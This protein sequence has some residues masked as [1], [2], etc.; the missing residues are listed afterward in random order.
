MIKDISNN[1]NKAKKTLGLIRYAAE[2]HFM[3]SSL[4]RPRY[5]VDWSTVYVSA[6][7]YLIFSLGGWTKYLTKSFE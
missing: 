7:H 1:I 2:K 4:V 6:E 3:F 5:L